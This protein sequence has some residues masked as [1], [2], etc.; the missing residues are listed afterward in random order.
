MGPIK[1][2]PLSSALLASLVPYGIF[3]DEIHVVKGSGQKK[4]DGAWSRP[5]YR[6][7]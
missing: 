7:K 5:M 1:V 6:P 2:E 3:E 4:S